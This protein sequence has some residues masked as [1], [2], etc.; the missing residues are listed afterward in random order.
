METD[1][2]GYSPE[3]LKD[4]EHGAPPDS[5]VAR[6]CAALRRAGRV[7]DC[8]RGALA[9]YADPDHWERLYLHGAFCDSKAMDDAGERARDALGEI[10]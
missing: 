4:L 7:N 9:F 10:S 5:D 2:A 8:L 6:L 3:E 1:F